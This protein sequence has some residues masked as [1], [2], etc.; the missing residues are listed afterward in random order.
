M[1]EIAT[2]TER[3][4]GTFEIEFRGSKYF[5]MYGESKGAFIIRIIKMIKEDFKVEVEVKQ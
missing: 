5:S 4:D 2:I 1:K 3:V